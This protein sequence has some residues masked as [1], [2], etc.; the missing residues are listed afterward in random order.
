MTKNGVF[1]LVCYYYFCLVS[2]KSRISIMYLLY[3]CAV[4]RPFT[5][6]DEELFKS[7][8]NHPLIVQYRPHR[9]ILPFGLL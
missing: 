1:Y 3:L 9:S 6:F 8:R 7:G 5:N 4:P 2:K